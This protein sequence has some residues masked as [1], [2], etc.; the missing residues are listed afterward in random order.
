MTF[1]KIQIASVNIRSFPKLKIWFWEQ[2]GS[3][4]RKLFKRHGEVRKRRSASRPCRLRVITSHGL[5]SYGFENKTIRTDADKKLQKKHET[6]IK[7]EANLFKVEIGMTVYT[8]NKIIRQTQLLYKFLN[9]KCLLLIIVFFLT[10][11]RPTLWF[12]RISIQC[13]S[14]ITY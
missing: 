2:F 7:S 1:S 8:I 9:I 13:A 12:I 6:L 5:G 14:M 3:A 4:P 11:K 10:H